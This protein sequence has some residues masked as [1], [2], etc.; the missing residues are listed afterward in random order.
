MQLNNLSLAFHVQELNKLLAGSYVNKLQEVAS[1]VFKLK[2]HSK[3]GTHNLIITLNNFFLTNYKIGA[4]KQTSGF[5][6]FLRKR[7]ENKKILS[8]KQHEADRIVLIEFDAYYLIL[9]LFAQGNIILTNKEFKTESAFKKKEEKERTIKKETI[10]QFPKTSKINPFKL[11]E[12]ELEKSLKNS[13]K[14]I[15]EAI[16][17]ELSIAPIVAEE[18]LFSAKISKEKFSKELNEKETKKL[19]NAIKELH[20]LEEKKMAPVFVLEN[21]EVLPFKFESIKQ[22]TKKIETIN[23][24]L[25]DNEAKQ[26]I[27]EKIEQKHSQGD[28]KLTALK[29]SIEKQKQAKTRLEK[30]MLENKQKAESIYRHFTELN[31]TMNQLKNLESIEENEQEI[32]YKMNLLLKN[33]KNSEIIVLA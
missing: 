27:A 32:M 10:Y 9:E 18:A 19:F 5:G 3:Q 23:E 31:E 29:K 25:D 1:D 17:Q 2:L 14:P 24:A 12:R 20:S 30:E 33:L 4:L 6:A 13:E 7:L 28:K 22:K 26:F 21:M 11:E 15:K 16:L 8:I